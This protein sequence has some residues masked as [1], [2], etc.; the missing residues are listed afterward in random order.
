MLKIRS[1]QLD[2]LAAPFAED[3]VRRACAQVEAQFPDAVTQLGADG[4]R[5]AVRRAI[6]RADVHELTRD[7]DVLGFVTLTFAFGRDFDTNLPWAAAVLAKAGRSMRMAE[8]EAEAACHHEE[9]T[10]YI[11]AKG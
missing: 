3:F 6:D 7:G 11:G 5:E 10:G 4:T 2:A 9:A 1:A 8:L